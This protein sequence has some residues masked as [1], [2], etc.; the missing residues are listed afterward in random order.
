VPDRAAA[1][2]LA[3]KLKARGLPVNVVTDG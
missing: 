1:D 2:K 3:A